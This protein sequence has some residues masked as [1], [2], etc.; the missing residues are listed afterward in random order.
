MTRKMPPVPP[1]NQSHKGTGDTKQMPTD[2]T[3]H[4]QQRAENPEQQGQ[5]GNIKQNTT[6]QGYQQDR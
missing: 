6:N 2:Q 4:G 1:D 5:Q 3:R